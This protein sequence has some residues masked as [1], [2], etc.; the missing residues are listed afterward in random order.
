MTPAAKAAITATPK[1]LTSPW[2]IRMPKFMT[3]CW[4]LERTEHFMM[5][6][7]SRPSSRRSARSRRKAGTRSR[8]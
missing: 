2:I 3:D 4:I 1:L 8:L 7:I 5:R 6:T